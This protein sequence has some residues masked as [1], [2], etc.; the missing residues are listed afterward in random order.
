MPL[1]RIVTT[2]QPVRN[3]PGSW[4]APIIGR[5]NSISLAADLGRSKHCKRSACIKHPLPK[6]TGGIC[7]T[8]IEPG[9]SRVTY[10][11]NSAYLVAPGSG[12]VKG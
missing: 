1:T 11:G 7:R 2:N 4:P 6:L 8:L 10:P 9:W 3:L 12:R 5:I